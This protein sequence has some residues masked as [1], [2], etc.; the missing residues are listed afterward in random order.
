M[1]TR[2]LH[3]NGGNRSMFGE[4]RHGRPIRARRI[5]EVESNLGVH[6]HDDEYERAAK[7]APPARL[8][9]RVVEHIQNAIVEAEEHP[10]ARDLQDLLVKHQQRQ[11]AESREAKRVNALDRRIQRSTGTERYCALQEWSESLK[12]GK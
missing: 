7:D 6:G 2:F 1:I 11:A 9:P 8:K 5:R 3:E 12:K 10:I 4:D